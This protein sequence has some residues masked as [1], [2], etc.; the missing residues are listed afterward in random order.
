MN[1]AKNIA[2]CG[3]SAAAATLCL[4]CCALPGVKWAALILAVLAS[5]FV[6][7]PLL[8]TPKNI[9]WSL[10][11]YIAA[12]T[13][14]VIASLSNVM[15]IVPIVAV[16]MPTAIVKVYGESTKTTKILPTQKAN[17]GISTANG[18]T[19]GGDENENTATTA[20]A[21]TTATT[22]A[23]EDPFAY[24]EQQ[25][26]ETPTQDCTYKSV[27]R[28]STAVR[29]V[30]YYLLLEVGIALTLFAMHLVTPD[31]FQTLAHAWFFVPM[32]VVGQV[33]PPLYVRLLSGCLRTVV[34]ILRKV[35]K[36]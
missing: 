27:P 21:T 2:V 34:K 13:I 35:V 31:V 6:T 36:Q 19:N 30:L 1:K 26:A 11:T 32:L 15:Y 12:A 4:L 24:D 17:D 16:F 18:N 22:T 28:L 9:V 8:I 23:D 10:L 5:I 7:V 33:V 25:S 14:G 29:Y 3:I 20:T